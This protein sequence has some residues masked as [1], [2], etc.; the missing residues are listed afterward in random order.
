[1]E[2]CR[3]HDSNFGVSKSGID[4]VK[5]SKCCSKFC[6]WDR[7]SHS[8][9]IAFNRSDAVDTLLFVPASGDFCRD[10]GPLPRD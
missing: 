6:A 7:Y 9:C 8:A 5:L 3:S 2:R 10:S 1:M 4:D